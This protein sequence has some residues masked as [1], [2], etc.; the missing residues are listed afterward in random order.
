[1]LER[2]DY[3]QELIDLGCN[4]YT[5]GAVTRNTITGQFDIEG[6]VWLDDHDL[7]RLPFA[8]GKVGGYFDCAHNR[9]MTL[10]GAPTEVGGDFLCNCVHLATLDGMPKIIHGDF[11]YLVTALLQDVSALLDCTIDGSI[12]L[13]GTSIAQDRMKSMLHDLEYRK[14]SKVVCHLV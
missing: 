13:Y 11:L 9:F 1:M 7:K 14:M 8:F 5:L 4:P 6:S 3:K 2:R 10:E 12:H